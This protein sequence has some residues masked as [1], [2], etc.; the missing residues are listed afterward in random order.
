MTRRA[1]DLCEGTCTDLSDFEDVLGFDGASF[2]TVF[3]KDEESLVENGEDAKKSR[4]CRLLIK[5]AG[6]GLGLVYI[7]YIKY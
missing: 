5:V 2:F 4:E 3:Y 6:N 1:R 7:T